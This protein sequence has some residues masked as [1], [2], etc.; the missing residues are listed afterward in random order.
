[1]DFCVNSLKFSFP[2]SF[3]L[4]SSSP[5]L[6]INLP[7][8]NSRNPREN[9]PYICGLGARFG[10]EHLSEYSNRRD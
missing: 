7:D 5:N 2:D 6:L 9:I 8:W 4:L 10:Y 1:M 3:I